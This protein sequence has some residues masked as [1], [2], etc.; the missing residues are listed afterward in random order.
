MKTLVQWFLE[1]D[2]KL[3]LLV[4]VVLHNVSFIKLLTEKST[5]IQFCVLTAVH[6]RCFATFSV[7]SHLG[8]NVYGKGWPSGTASSTEIL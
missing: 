1:T 3:T 4:L 7:A 6:F 8:K 2:Q 5:K